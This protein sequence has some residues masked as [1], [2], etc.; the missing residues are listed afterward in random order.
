MPDE[1]QLEWAYTPADL[2]E[3]QAELLI[4]GCTFVIDAGRVVARAPFEGDPAAEGVLRSFCN[5]RHQELEAVFLAAQALEHK[6]CTL[7][8]SKSPV[9]LCPDGTRH[10]FLVAQ[11]LKLTLSLGRLD[12]QIVEA[13][14]RI[15]D[16][17]AARIAKRKELAQKAATYLTDPTANAILRS[18]SA[19][20]IDPRNELVHLYEI[21]ETL[22]KHFGSEKNTREALGISGAEWKTLGRLACVEPLLQGW[23][24]GRARS[25]SN[26][27]CRRSVRLSRPERRRQDDDGAD[28]V[29]AAAAD[30]R[31][32]H[33]RRAGRGEKRRPSTEEDR[34]GAAG[35]R[36]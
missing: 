7:S 9:R 1:I 17:R 13:G 34:R 36:A 24:R 30:H 20:V 21:R 19:A 16:T 28:V 31:E 4:G 25:R 3:E 11:S 33:R 2:F 12:V 23:D 18:Y 6:T 26:G 15:V 27:R 10:P 32:C 35:D 14:G 29:H 22:A 5:A 8:E